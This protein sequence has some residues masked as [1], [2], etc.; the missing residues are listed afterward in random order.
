MKLVAQNTYVVCKKV[1]DDFKEV[2][3]NG[4]TY[5][6]SNIPI[7]QVLNIGSKVDEK[8]FKVGDNVM[9]HTSGTK[10]TL[11]NNEFYLFDSVNFV[12]C[13]C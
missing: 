4:F 3:L 10:V 5:K 8:L 9:F 2:N 12:G 7:Y 11:D 13:V 1:Q 6:T